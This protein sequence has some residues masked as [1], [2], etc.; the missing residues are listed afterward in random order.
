MNPANPISPDSFVNVSASSETI[1][2]ESN[3][4]GQLAGV[5]RSDRI[6]L[7]PIHSAVSPWGVPVPTPSAV[8]PWDVPVP[9]TSA[10]FAEEYPRLEWR[11]LCHI[12]I[13]K[14]I[15]TTSLAKIR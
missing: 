2:H 8:P 10:V 7:L 4:E 9:T 3:N 11:V 14:Y 12:L 15:V 13:N 5:P 1:G 6:S